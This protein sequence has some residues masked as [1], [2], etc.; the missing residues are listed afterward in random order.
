MAVDGRSLETRGPAQPPSRRVNYGDSYR[1]G[2][3]SEL[4]CGEERAADNVYIT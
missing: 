4:H 1:H 3:A 2:W